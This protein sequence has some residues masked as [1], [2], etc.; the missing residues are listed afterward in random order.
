MLITFLVIFKTPSVILIPNSINFSTRPANPVGR[1]EKS[2]AVCRCF[3][4]YNASHS[5]LAAAINVRRKTKQKRQTS[6]NSKT[7]LSHMPFAFFWARISQSPLCHP[8]PKV[9]EPKAP[10]SFE[11][12]VVWRTKNIFGEGDSFVPLSGTFSYYNIKKKKLPVLFWRFFYN[13]SVLL[14]E[15]CE[16]YSCHIISGC[17]SSDPSLDKCSPEHW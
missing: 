9:L 2:L 16:M 17:D 4:D 11:H 10:H 5:H 12:S 14:Q 15:T 6:L 3:R 7:Y 8:Y 1:L 13:Q